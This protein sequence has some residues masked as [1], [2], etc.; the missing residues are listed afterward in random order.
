MYAF[1]P[2][3]VPVRVREFAPVEILHRDEPRAA[4]LTEREH[5]ADVLVDELAREI[6]FVAEHRDEVIV[7][8]E[9]RQD[10]LEHHHVVFA[11]RHTA[12]TRGT[13]EIDLGHA[14]RREL[15]EQLVRAKISGIARN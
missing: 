9:V 7:L 1:L 14:A 4:V 2:L 10:P 8:G 5:L 3:T 12:R 15:R 13:R 11:R 6:G